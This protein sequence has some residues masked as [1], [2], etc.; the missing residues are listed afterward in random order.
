LIDVCSGAGLA[1]RDI[2][3]FSGNSFPSVLLRRAFTACVACRR[4][5]DMR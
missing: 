2:A 1:G 3:G 5:C 4:A